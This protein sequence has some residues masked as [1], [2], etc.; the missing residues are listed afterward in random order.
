[1]RSRL[2]PVLTGWLF[3]VGALAGPIDCSTLSYGAGIDSATQ[4]LSLD[5][6]GSSFNGLMRDA[7]SQVGMI[8]LHGRNTAF[9]GQAPVHHPN[10]VVVQQLRG[11]LAGLGYSTLSIETPDIPLSANLNGNST[12]DFFEYDAHNA[13]LTAEMFA[14]I[15]AAIDELAAHSVQRVVLAGFS[16]GSR[17]A[18]A[19]TAAASLGLLGNSLDVVGLIGVGMDATPGTA[20]PTPAMPTSA[21]DINGYNIGSN[22]P[23]VAVPVLDIYGSLDAGVADFAMARALGYGGDPTDYTQAELAC[24]DFVN[25]AYY[26]RQQGVYRTYTENRCHQLRNGFLFDGTNYI[27]D[28]LLVNGPDRPLESTVTAWLAANNGFAATVPLPASGLL[29]LLGLTVWRLQAAGRRQA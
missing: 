22:L 17:Y 14:R 4:C 8:L 13:S 25:Q 6:A 10:A 24:P 18:T 26:W 12:A 5:T 7:G 21:A 19:A 15:N 9:E 20:M 3:S 29:L 1:M 2:W 28:V 16:M 11:H 23:H 27:P